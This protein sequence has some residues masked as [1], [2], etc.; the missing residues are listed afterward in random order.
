VDGPPRRR[1]DPPEVRGDVSSGFP[2]PLAADAGFSP[3]R[4]AKKAWQ[5]N[6]EAIQHWVANDYPRIQKKWPI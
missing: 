3:Q 2:S 6:D 5:R 4:P 1:I